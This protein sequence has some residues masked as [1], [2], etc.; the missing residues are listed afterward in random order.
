[1]TGDDSHSWA[2]RTFLK[3]TGAAGAAAAVTTTV[4]ADTGQ[5]KVRLNFG[6]ANSASM[7]T[8]EAELQSETPGNAE[9]YRRSND[10]GFISM[11]VPKQAAENVKE[12]FAKK[13]KF[14]YVEYDQQLH[15]METP[16]DELLDEQYAPQQVRAPTAYDTTS[17]SSDVTISVVDQGVYYDHPDLQSRF[18]SVKG[19]DFVDSDSDPAPDSMA[20]EYH[21][22][23]VAGIASATTDNT[24][25]IAGISDS[26]LLSGR[27]LSEEGSGSTADIAEAVRWSADQGAD[28]I[29]LSL[30][31]GGYTDTMKNAVSYAVSNGALPICAA[32]NDGSS[33]VSYPAAYSECVAVSAV[34]SNE[35][36]ASFSQYGDKCDVAAPG[37]DV[38]SCWTEDQSTYGGKYNKISGTSMACPAASGVAALGLAAEPGLS[39]NELRNRLKNTAVDIGLSEQ[40]QGAGRVDAANIV[41]AGTGGGNDGPSASFTVNPSSPTAGESATFDASGS[42][43]PDGSISSYEWDFGDGSTDGGESVS[44]TYGS[45]GDYSVS[46][47]VTDDDGATDTATETVSVQSDGGGNGAPTASFSVS[48]TAPVEG[49]T[50]SVDAS[51]SSDGDGSIDSYEWD[52]GDGSTASGV[53]ASNAYASA[54]DYAITLTVT[55]DD[56]ASDTASQSVTVE[57][58]SG[59]SCGDTST[60]ESADGYLYGYYDDQSFTYGIELA[61][62]CQATVSLEGPSGTDFD[63]YVTFDGRTPSTYDYDARSITYGSDEQIVVDDVDAG[64]EFGILVDSY[65]GSGSFTVT[66]DELGK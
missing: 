39:P 42:S 62:P 2:R 57:S 19:K 65:D 63:L 21:G 55:D 28:V 23:H 20:D 10:L 29:N 43:D 45:A 25:G 26:T 1:M 50:V 40:E 44:H 35:Q 47:T 41:D 13:D 30:G 66:V 34:D 48:P 5:E 31:G 18:G 8:A 59:G 24:T 7:S 17:G 60:S 32:G 12:A 33:S 58:E 49:E 6:T 36:L 64:Q 51:A 46:L 3:T 38:L 27:A 37:V 9:V 14:R 4:S 16:N 61:D 52:F 22:T 11:D 15:A 54:G 56:G 53:T